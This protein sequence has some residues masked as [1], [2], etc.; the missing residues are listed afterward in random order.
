[1]E[2]LNIRS[3]ILALSALLFYFLI[4]TRTREHTARLRRSLFQFNLRSAATQ[5][6]FFT[7]AVSGSVL[8]LYAQK[9]THVAVVIL[10]SE[11]YSRPAMAF[12]CYQRGARSFV[13]ARR[14]IRK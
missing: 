6:V 2:N 8:E 14:R 4:F 10:A 3:S 1:M 9:A 11:I 7:V 5:F 12:R 13:A